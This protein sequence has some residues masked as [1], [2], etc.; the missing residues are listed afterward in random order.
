MI[1]QIADVIDNSVPRW[2]LELSDIEFTVWFVSPEE[3]Y[4]DLDDYEIP[5]TYTSCEKFAYL[6]LEK[7]KEHNQN[8]EYGITYLEM[9]IVIDILKWMV[10]NEDYL[11]GK[12]KLCKP[13]K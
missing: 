12:M 10:E 8:A 4:C 1:R 7:Y 9:Q 5:V 13:E 11:L 3:D 2:R 6:D